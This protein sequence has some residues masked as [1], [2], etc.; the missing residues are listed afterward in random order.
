MGLLMGVYPKPRTGD[1]LP[2]GILV[3]LSPSGFHTGNLVLLNHHGIWLM[4]LTFLSE[5]VLLKIGT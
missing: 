3:V 4:S 2:A 1:V 5:W